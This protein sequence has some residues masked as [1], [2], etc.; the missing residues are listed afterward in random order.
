[1]EQSTN[2]QIEVPSKLDLVVLHGAGHALLTFGHDLRPQAAARKNRAR[3]KAQKHMHRDGPQRWGQGLGR[4]PRDLNTPIIT[5]RLACPQQPNVYLEPKWL[6]CQKMK[7]KSSHMLKF[8]GL[9]LN[10]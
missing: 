9:A 6:R 10:R 1:M 2:D 5:K 4:Q 3:Q 8:V 7:K